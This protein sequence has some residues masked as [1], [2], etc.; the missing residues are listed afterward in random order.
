VYFYTITIPCVKPLIYE[1]TMRDGT[2]IPASIVFDNINQRFIV[3]SISEFDVG[4]L[5]ILLTISADN[6]LNIVTD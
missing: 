2:P 4:T 1:A 6:S 3:Y 5:T